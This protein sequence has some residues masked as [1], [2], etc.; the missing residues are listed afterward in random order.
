MSEAPPP[1]RPLRGS[2]WNDAAAGSPAAAG[3]Y[4]PLPGA[5]AASERAPRPPA[6]AAPAATTDRRVVALVLALGV[7]AGA[8]LAAAGAG[9]GANVGAAG[10]GTPV[11]TTTPINP[12]V[13]PPEC[14]TALGGGVVGPGGSISPFASRDAT[15]CRSALAA[16][17]QQPGGAY[18]QDV[19]AAVAVAYGALNITGSSSSSSQGNA[20]A[21]SHRRRGVVIFDIDET[22]LSN[23]P[24]SASFGAQRRH[25]HDRNGARRVW[26]GD[27]P[28][29]APTLRLYRA[30][31]DA[32]LSAAFVTG[33]G[34][35]ARAET[36][37]NLASAGYGGRCGGGGGDEDGGGGVAGSRSQYCYLS[38]TLR[39]PGD[40]RPA[41]VYKPEARAGVAAATGLPVVASV[42]DQWSD[43]SG[44][45]GPRGGC[46]AEGEGADGSAPYVVIK[47]PNPFYYIL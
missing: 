5:A 44:G 18:W 4:D 34:E 11:T 28:A 29:L 32:G 30:L 43:L 6:A 26:R 12:P 7:V 15:N 20:A 24:L 21:S 27:A 8:S 10:V 22:A 45:A 42:G 23:A 1:P 9:A 46:Q 40:A 33:R 13:I 14:V 2:G 39:R 41:S 16:Y 35:S 3:G 17:G 19:E 25:H 31:Q 37:R 38:L 47:L 36:E